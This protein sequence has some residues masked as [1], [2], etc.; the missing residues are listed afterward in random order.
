MAEKKATIS[1]EGF[2]EAYKPHVEAILGKKVSK[3]TA[4]KLFKA[5]ALL[6]F[7]VAEENNAN[8]SLA[9]VGRFTILVSGREGAKKHPKFYGSSSISEALNTGAPILAAVSAEADEA[10]EAPAK[11]VAADIEEEDL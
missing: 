4:W 7:Q 1:K 10:V 5:S 8:I 2:I 6:P 3:D 9:G 11:E